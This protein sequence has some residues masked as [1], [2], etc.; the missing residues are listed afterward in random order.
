[1]L[2]LAITNS[3]VVVCLTII[4]STATEFTHITLSYVHGRTVEKIVVDPSDQIAPIVDV[5]KRLFE[6]PAKR[7]R[8]LKLLFYRD[9]EEYTAFAIHQQMKKVMDSPPDTLRK[10][11]LWRVH[12]DFA[13]LQSLTQGMMYLKQYGL[14]QFR[15]HLTEKLIAPNASG[16]LTAAKQAIKESVNFRNLLNLVDHALADTSSDV[17]P[18][19]GKLREILIEFFRDHQRRMQ[20]REARERQQ[21]AEGRATSTALTASQEAR[22]ETR[23]II[24]A[25]YVDTVDSVVKML[26]H[27]AP[28]IKPARFLGQGG[29]KTKKGKSWHSL[30]CLSLCLY[31]MGF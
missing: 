3:K 25:G 27:C 22:R 5:Y 17:H 23:V 19:M 28:L 26:S 15:E 30:M 13:C 4:I 16:R 31:S 12:G 24:F 2:S 21:L 1:M 10:E 8:D 14:G 11:D 20:E 9:P 6:I 18:K 7:L 29:T